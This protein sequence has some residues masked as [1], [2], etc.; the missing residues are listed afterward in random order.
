MSEGSDELVSFRW[1][2]HADADALANALADAIADVIE[3]AIAAR[4]QAILALAGGTTP[5]SAYRRLAR[6]RLPWDRVIITLTD[7]RLVPLG[8]P[9]SNV[10][11]LATIFAPLGVRIE[12]LTDATAIDHVAAG[13]AADQRL[14]DGA[15][16]LDFVLLGVGVDGHTASLFPGADYLAAVDPFSSARALGVMPD[17]MPPEA[18][19]ARVSLSLAAIAAARTVVVAATGPVKRGVIEEA[20][21]DGGDSR[22]PIGRVLAAV[23]TPVRIYWA[24]Q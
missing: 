16:P 17:P 21:A 14:R 20:I 10:S 24:P 11:G 15:W 3:S 23:R 6:E 22:F 9:L 1:C 2:D 5:W 7:D 13:R 8:D 12:P 4:G 18:P 19:V